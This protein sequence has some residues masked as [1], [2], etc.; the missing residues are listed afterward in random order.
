MLVDVSK[1]VSL[2]FGLVFGVIQVAQAQT[3][4]LN[5]PGAYNLKDS[6]YES[7]LSLPTVSHEACAQAIVQY[8]R[9]NL[10]NFI[11]CDVQPLPD[12]VN[13]RTTLR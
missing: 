4:W 10:V 1:K 11:G 13:I 7:S 5:I 8:T 6:Q 3:Y 9:D 2:I 12:A